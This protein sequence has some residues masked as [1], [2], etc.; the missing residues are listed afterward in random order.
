MSEHVL[1]VIQGEEGM[2]MGEGVRETRI[3]LTS[4]ITKMPEY[5]EQLGRVVS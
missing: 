2:G 3:K 1:A 5:H 4:L